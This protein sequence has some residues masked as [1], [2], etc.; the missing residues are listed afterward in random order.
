VR[1][2]RLGDFG[3]YGGGT[4]T[5]R[6]DQLAGWMV[7]VALKFAADCQKSIAQYPNIKTGAEFTGYS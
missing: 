7:G 6:I 5:P 1:Q 4:P 2:R 3:V